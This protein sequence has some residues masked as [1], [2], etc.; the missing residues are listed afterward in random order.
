MRL[1]RHASLELDGIFVC[2]LNSVDGGNAFADIVPEAVGPDMIQRKRPGPV[3][4]EDISYR[5]ALSN[6]L[7]TT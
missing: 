3:R 2:S 4:F 5:C 6:G 1:A 7:H